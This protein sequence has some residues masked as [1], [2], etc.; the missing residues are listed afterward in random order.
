MLGPIDYVAVG[1]KGNK[2]D[3]SILSEL[4]KAVESKDIRVVDLLFI[5]K[6]DEGNVGATEV[7]DQ[8]DDLKEV[9]GTLGVDKD[10]P[11]LAEQDVLKVGESMPN[12]TSAG[13]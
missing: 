7:A 10:M 13:V 11:L 6:D 3:G 2:F 12:N 4:S 8:S 5:V 1:F 9:I